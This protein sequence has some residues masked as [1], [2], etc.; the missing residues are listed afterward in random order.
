MKKR[1]DLVK[2][3]KYY[4]ITVKKE[5]I[6]KI[7]I[8]G[9]FSELRLSMC[10]RFFFLLKY[11]KFLKMYTRIKFICFRSYKTHSLYSFFNLYRMV[12]RENMLYGNY[13]GFKKASW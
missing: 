12:I 8:K 7:Y 3:L 13:S 5:E 10:E 2:K 1:K 11:V 6:K 9:F 4:L